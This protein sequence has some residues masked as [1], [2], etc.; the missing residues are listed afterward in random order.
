VI[1]LPRA[2]LL[3]GREVKEGRFVPRVES[4]GLESGVIRFE[5]NP[6]IS[7]AIPPEL[8]ARVNASRDSIV[9]GTLDPVQSTDPALATGH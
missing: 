9:A 3:I 7:G 8:M 4:F 2:F 5:T 6:A 1:D